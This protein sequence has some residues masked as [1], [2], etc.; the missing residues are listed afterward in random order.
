MSGCAPAIDAAGNV[1]VQTGNGAFD[2]KLD[3]GMS[4]LKISPMLA[5]V[6]SY[7]TPSTYEHDNN[8]DIDLGSA[9]AILLPQAAGNYQVAVGGGKSGDTYL[10]NEAN[11]G[12]LQPSGD[13]NVLFWAKTNAGL[14]GTPATYIGA[15]GNTYLFVPGSGPMTAWKVTTSPGPGLVKVG[16]TPDAFG[17][18][19][20]GGTIPVISS[21]GTT[22]GTAIVWAYSRSPAPTDITLRAYDAA[23]LSDEL[24]EIPF[25]KWEVN[26][27]SLITPMV[28]NGRVYAGGA[29]V[30]KAYGLLADQRSGFRSPTHSR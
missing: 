21:N 4:M 24:I 17:D 18:G 3:W 14:W 25:T 15:D 26:G 7:F 2:G 1:Y 27:T 5:G 22:A 6:L 9:G 13:P 28:A 29:G 23:N 20:N 10:L 11:L 30:L 19:N 12:G 16:H 8:R